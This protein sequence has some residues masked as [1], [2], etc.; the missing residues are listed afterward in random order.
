M[1]S[2]A[3]ELH[4]ERLKLARFNN[5]DGE[6]VGQ[7]LRQNQTLWTS[8]VFGRFQYFELIELRDLRYGVVNADTLYLVTDKA[9]LADLLIVLGELSADEIS[10]TDKDDNLQYG[11]G[12]GKNE[13]LVRVWWD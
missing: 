11:G 12:L 4:F 6:Y 2:I 3:Q 7:L 5:F 8:F 1:M 13:V 9:K 10:Y